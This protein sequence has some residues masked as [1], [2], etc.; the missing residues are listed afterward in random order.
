MKHLILCSAIS[1]LMLHAS[2]QSAKKTRTIT[3]SIS[4]HGSTSGDTTFFS[5]YGPAGDLMRFSNRN[6][7]IPREEGTG[8]LEYGSCN[9]HFMID[10]AGNVTKTWCDSVTSQVVEKEILRVAGKLAWIKPTKIKGKPVVTNVMATIVMIYNEVY[11]SNKNV[12]A[13]IVVI[14]YGEQRKKQIAAF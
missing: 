7:R 10:T 1:L 11:D 2:A 9:L 12:K 5:Y 14:G 4:K 3:A 13:D 8:E 6:L